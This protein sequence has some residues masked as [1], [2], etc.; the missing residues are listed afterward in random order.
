MI[1]N[2]YQHGLIS[3]SE[4]IIDLEIVD[5]ATNMSLRFGTYLSL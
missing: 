5:D 3:T 4:L 1:D 2:V